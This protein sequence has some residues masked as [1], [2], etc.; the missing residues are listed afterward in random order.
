MSE[1]Q[2]FQDDV[3]SWLDEQYK[4]DRMLTGNIVELM[5]DHLIVDIRG[6]QGTVEHVTLGV[7]WRMVDLT[8]EEQQLSEEE[9]IYQRLEALKGQEIQV[10]ILEVNRPLHILSLE[11]STKG[12]LDAERQRLEAQLLATLR[13]GDVCKGRVKSIY[14][15]QV[16]VDI[17]GIEG[18]IPPSHISLQ[19]SFIDPWRVVQPGQEVDVMILDKK[20]EQLVLS[21]TYA[22]RR[23]EVLG[24]LKLDLTYAGT[25]A[26]LDN[27]G[28]YVDLDGVL[29]M[30][31]AAQAV[32]GYITH[33]AD[34]YHKGQHVVVRIQKIASDKRVTA[35]LVQAD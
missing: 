2:Q 10:R 6:I 15:H 35:T 26:T 1:E 9:L 7:N 25:I 8:I 5:G 28:V 11:L 34:L 32:S 3:W 19:K 14:S 21:L 17:G 24:K 33:P 22:Q 4:Y 12:D 27:E 29:A 31:P 13:P 30:I 16:K 23:D 20:P 18:T